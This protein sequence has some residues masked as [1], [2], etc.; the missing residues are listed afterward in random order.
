MTVGIEIPDRSLA[1]TDAELAWLT[2]LCDLH[3]GPVRQPTLAAVQALRKAMEGPAWSRPLQPDP[4]IPFQFHAY[5]HGLFVLMNSCRLSLL[6][7]VQL[8]VDP[9]QRRNALTDSIRVSA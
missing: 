9:G 4:E 2:F 5:R 1:V 3:E 8:F 6:E 7:E